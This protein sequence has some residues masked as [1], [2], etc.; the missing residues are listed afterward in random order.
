MGA[1]DEATSETRMDMTPMID[2]TFQLI[3][4]FMCN[5]KFRMLE[6][7]LQTYLPKDVGVNPTQHEHVLE[8]IDIR[9]ERTVAKSELGLDDVARFR[10]WS[11]AGGTTMGQVRILLRGEPVK[12]MEALRSRLA[13]IRARIPGPTDAADEDSIKMNLEPLPGV[14]YEDVVRVVDVA[15]DAKFTSLTFRGVPIDA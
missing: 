3:I 5:I 9:I 11:D 6:G 13:A 8:K 2:V 7:K 10:K 4:F 1:R 15:L 12:D 14:L